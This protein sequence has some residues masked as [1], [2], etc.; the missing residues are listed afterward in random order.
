[1]NTNATDRSGVR[2]SVRRSGFSQSA[3]RT[4]LPTDWSGVRTEPPVQ[5]RETSPDYC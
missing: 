3:M 4:A 2:K 5:G 1:M